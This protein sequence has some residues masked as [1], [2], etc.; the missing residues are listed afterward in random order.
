VVWVIVHLRVGFL[1]AILAQRRNHLLAIFDHL[2][3]VLLRNLDRVGIVDLPRRRANDRRHALRHHDVAVVRLVQTI[4]HHL[5][6]PLRHRDHNARRRQHRH[7]DVGEGRNVPRS[8]AGGV[9]HEVRADLI[10]FPGAMIA[11]LDT[12]HCIARHQQSRYFMIR[13]D[14]RAV[15]L[16]RG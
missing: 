1:D 4:D 16:G 3:D 2:V 8:R 6:Q 12:A 10:L 14:L 13:Q 7:I 5:I 11:H 9:H 15:L